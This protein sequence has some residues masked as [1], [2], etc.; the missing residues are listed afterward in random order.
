[1]IHVEKD[2]RLLDS[3]GAADY[4][5]Q[6][7]DPV[8]TYLAGSSAAVP[9]DDSPRRKWFPNN[10]LTPAPPSA[11]MGFWPGM[12][13]LMPHFGGPPAGGNY[14]G[15]CCVYH[16]EAD[17]QEDARLIEESL[18]GRTAAFGDLVTKYQDRLFNS[19]M[20]VVGSAEEAQD[21]VQDSFVQ[22]FVNLESFKRNSAF[23]TWLYRIAFNVAI[24]RRR[25]KRPTISIDQTREATGMDPVDDG[26]SP[27]HRMEQQDR[28]DM[29]RQA[30]KKL[31]EPF[32]TVLVLRE[33][34]GFDYETI[35]DML[36]LPVGTVRS[37]LHRA[38]MQMKELLQ[39]VLQE[40][41][42]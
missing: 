15:G 38:R 21:V 31:P 9:T 6:L 2:D 13:H 25:R 11:M 29:V 36:D 40:D 7:E 22:A 5:V 4:S 35:A 34:D 28:C 17:V 37:R 10:G 42:R 32:R 18:A 41:A 33:M 26:P 19:V 30:L 14:P 3:D 16:F 8:G 12:S 23:Y 1:M 39:I 20:H 24:S 27:E